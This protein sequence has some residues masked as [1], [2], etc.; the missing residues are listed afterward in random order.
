M[1]AVGTLVLAIGWMAQAEAVAPVGSL[2]GPK[3]VCFGMSS[4]ALAAGERLELEYLGIHNVE[5][6]VTGPSGTY[7]IR[8][9]EIFAIPRRPGTRVHREGDVSIFRSR[10]RPYSYAVMAPTAFSP[11]Q[12]QM[13]AVIAGD[14]FTGRRQ[15]AS[16]YRRLTVGDP[17]RLRCDYTFAYGWSAILQD[18]D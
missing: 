7:T 14:A 15:D 11:D 4:F 6:R 13:I 10:T 8:E 5:V 9:S 16:V 1:V 12:P 17:A 3:A 2:D 18:S